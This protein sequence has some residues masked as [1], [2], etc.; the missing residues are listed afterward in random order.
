MVD[1]L[2]LV[3]REWSECK[4]DDLLRLLIEIPP[5]LAPRAYSTM[6]F[7]ILLGRNLAAFSSNIIPHVRASP[8]YIA[9]RTFFIGVQGL[10]RKLKN[11]N[12]LDIF[13]GK[14]KGSSSNK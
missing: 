8:K 4:L 12:C 14:Q 7:L 6:I 2:R 10:S 13:V 1:S 3:E 9:K 5:F 11:Q